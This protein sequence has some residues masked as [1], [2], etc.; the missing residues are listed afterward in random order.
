MASLSTD[1]PSYSS[2]CM[3]PSMASESS[4]SS[5]TDAGTGAPSLRRRWGNDMLGVQDHEANDPVS[6]DG[7]RA[8]WASPP[9]AQLPAKCSFGDSTLPRPATPC[10]RGPAMTALGWASAAHAAPN[11]QRSSS[12]SLRHTVATEVTCPVT[13]PQTPRRAVVASNEDVIQVS[14]RTPRELRPLDGE[15]SQRSREGQPFRSHRSQP[16]LLG[17][18]CAADAAT[19][20]VQPT[21][22][23]NNTT[24]PLLG[25]SLTRM[26]TQHRLFVSQTIHT[27]QP[28]HPQWTTAD[29]AG[30]LNDVAVTNTVHRVA[31]RAILV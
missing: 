28:M 14:P 19:F 6:F 5:A 21:P 30:C 24:A 2:T 10:G 9:C 29:A 13:L 3:R 31:E 11:L 18:S 23:K 4:E 17:A 15:V 26:D 27:S 8:P 20:T 16:F 7:Q 22:K 1:S 12:C 25:G